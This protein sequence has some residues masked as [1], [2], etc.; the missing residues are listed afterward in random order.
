MS[1][2]FACAESANPDESRD[3]EMDT[4]DPVNTIHPDVSQF[5]PPNCSSPNADQSSVDDKDFMM[6]HY[7][8]HDFLA[9]LNC[10]SK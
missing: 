2:P 4:E 10:A 7:K 3:N 6:T 1:G 9:L 8:A 5:K